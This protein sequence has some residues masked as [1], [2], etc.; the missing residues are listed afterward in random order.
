MWAMRSGRLRSVQNAQWYFLVLASFF[1]TLVRVGCS[2]FELWAS[3]SGWSRHWTLL[4]EQ[5]AS[6]T[7]MK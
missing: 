1:G 6:G 2:G 3:S 7:E 4:F 5:A